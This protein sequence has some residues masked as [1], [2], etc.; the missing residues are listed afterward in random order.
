MPERRMLNFAS[1]EEI[2][3]DVVRLLEGYSTIGQWTLAQ[4]LHHLATSIRLTYVWGG[5]PLRG[6][7]ACGDLAY[8][9]RFFERTPMFFP[10]NRSDNIILRLPGIVGICP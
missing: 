7:D 5:G 2:M 3:P 4:I 9:P 1:M 10:E 8:F 6:R